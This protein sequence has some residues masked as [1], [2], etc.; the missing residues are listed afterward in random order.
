MRDKDKLKSMIATTLGVNEA[1]ITDDFSLRVQKLKTSAGSVIL[2]NIVKKIYGRKVDCRNVS[3]FGELIARI[4]GK[5]ASSLPSDI[6]EPPKISISDRKR[7]YGGMVC[8]IDIQEIDIFPESEDYW[9]ESFYTD[10]FTDD[11]IAY[12]AASESP[13]HSFAA[14]WCLKEAL[15]KC[16]ERYY[17][18]PFDKI[19]S[20]KT[21]GGILKI[22]VLNEEGSWEQLAFACSISH[23]DNYA[24]GMVT[25]IDER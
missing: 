6:S 2:S 11:E 5:A 1:D 19:R 15:H 12:C 25:G 13:R 22:E 21:T 20:V 4:E 24:V 23:A 16:G 9:N 10:N 17:G 7:A 3:T 8:G 14:R 18:I